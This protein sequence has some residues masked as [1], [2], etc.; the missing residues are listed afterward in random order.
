MAFSG[1]AKRERFVPI[2]GRLKSRYWDEAEIFF[3]GVGSSL[4]VRYR[5]E[6]ASLEAIALC[7]AEQ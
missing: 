1:Y 7:A 2:M 5:N 6:T 3:I 4:N